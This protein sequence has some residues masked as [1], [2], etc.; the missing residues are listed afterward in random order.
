[1]ERFSVAFSELRGRKTGWLGRK[2][3]ALCARAAQALR[4]R[5]RALHARSHSLPLAY[6]QHDL[7]LS[8]ADR[9]VQ[10]SRA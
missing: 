3:N 5:R 1:M 2:K 7:N 10:T 9:L 4:C 6:L 8:L